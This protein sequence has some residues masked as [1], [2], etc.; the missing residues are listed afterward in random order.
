VQGFQVGFARD[1]RIERF[2]PLRRIKE[3]RRAFA[4]ATDVQ[5]D[6]PAKS[7]GHSDLQRI[8]WRGRRPFEE[9]QRRLRRTRRGTLPAA[10]ANARLARRA[11]SGVSAGRSL[12]GRP[13]LPPGRHGSRPVGRALQLSGEIFVSAERRLA[14]GAT[15]GDQGLP[16]YRSP[17][18]ARG[19]P[20]GRSASV[21][22][23]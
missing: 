14:R 18:P 15:L 13:L 20:S 4:A 5:C 6:P 3:D 2:E 11:W 8:H 21:A 16:A 10:A 23:R 7:L 9:R 22:A 17:R 19:G 12:E 1:S